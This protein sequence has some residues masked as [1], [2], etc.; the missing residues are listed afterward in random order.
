MA[1]GFRG[2][3][4]HSAGRRGLFF[5]CIVALLVALL[6][7]ASGGKVSAAA[8]DVVAPVSNF[9]DKLGA[10]ITKSGY[11]STRSALEAQVAA[12]QNEVEQ[13]Q[14]QAAAFEAVQQENASLSQLTHLAQTS[15]GLAAPVTSSIISSPYG[16]FTI[17][18]GSA[19]GV[20]QGS[21]VLT[22]DGFV[23]GKVAQVQA[24]QSLVDEIFAPGAQTPVSIDGTA[25]VLSGQ[26]D[27]AQTEIPHGVAVS[28]ND[29]VIAPE[30]EGRPVG[31]VQHVDS[32]PANAQQAVYVALPVS[33]SSLQFVYVTP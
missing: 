6:N 10:G 4:S 8:R 23:V 20:S 13:Q 17:G 19:D 30:L 28:Q 11:F 25:A 21:L 7:F 33:L 29:S 9:G 18:A 3:S 1:N 26:G 32:N 14:L 22:A 31:I 12:L 5:V 16:T 15:P 24:H 2:P 27:E